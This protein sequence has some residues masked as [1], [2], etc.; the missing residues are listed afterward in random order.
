MFKGLKKKIDP[1]AK[2]PLVKSGRHKGKQFTLIG[3]LTELGGYD[4]AVLLDDFAD[5]G[6]IAA[7]NAIL[8]DNYTNNDA[9]FYYVKIREN[10]SF[11]GYIISQKDLY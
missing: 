5:R 4:G 6:N 10:E 3:E 1:F 2:W 11:L 7:M 8:K 9:P